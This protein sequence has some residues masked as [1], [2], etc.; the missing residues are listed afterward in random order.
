MY[1]DPSPSGYMKSTPSPFASSGE[2]LD[3]SN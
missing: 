2:S 1:V 3:T